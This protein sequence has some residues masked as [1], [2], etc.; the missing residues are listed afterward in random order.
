MSRVE[1]IERKLDTMRY[2]DTIA[3]AYDELYAGE[4]LSKYLTLLSRYDIGGSL[5]DIGCGTGIFL[6]L[7]AIRARRVVGLDIS[8]VMLRKARRRL[9]GLDRAD[10]V[11]GDA[12]KLPFI[13]KAF[14]TVT[15]FTVVQNLPS[16]ERCLKECMRMARRLVVVTLLKKWRGLRK[17]VEFLRK[18]H[19]DLRILDAGKDYMVLI[20]LGRA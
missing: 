14:D 2:Y 13:D 18:L 16:P 8:K 3:E 15:L 5:L 12:E 4:Q 17:V 10:L 9:Q 1:V 7:I 20:R 6:S 19:S 11:L